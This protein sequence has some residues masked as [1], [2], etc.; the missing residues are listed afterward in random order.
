MG[1]LEE[2]QGNDKKVRNTIGASPS[3]SVKI[4]NG[5]KDLSH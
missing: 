4:R 5:A 1:K 2:V 3:K